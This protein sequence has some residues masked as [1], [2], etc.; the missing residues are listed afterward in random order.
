MTSS[1]IEA[2]SEAI[3]ALSDLRRKTEA[4]AVLEESDGALQDAL[5]RRADDLADLVD[6]LHEM[7]MRALV[8]RGK[9]SEAPK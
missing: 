9:E 1:E 4:R 8:G 5:L 6:R 3:C 2:L 7:V